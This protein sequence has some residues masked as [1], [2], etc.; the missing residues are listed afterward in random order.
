MSL[1]SVPKDDTGG[2]D[3]ERFLME[4]R[5]KNR[6]AALKFHC[7]GINCTM[8][9]LDLVVHVKMSFEV[10]RR[11]R[12]SELLLLREI[13]VYRLVPKFWN[14]LYRIFLKQVAKL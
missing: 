10:A 14:I 2:S 1:Q 11:W 5:I 9:T 7:R 4:E 6:F 13:Y 8:E 12:D 3:I